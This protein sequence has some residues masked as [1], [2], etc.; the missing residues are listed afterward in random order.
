[1]TKE[2][3]IIPVDDDSDEEKYILYRPLIA[4]AFVG[5]R[6]MVDYVQERLA[7]A[8]TAGDKSD[9]ALFLHSIGFLV[10]DPP[11]PAEMGGEFS[12]ITAVLLLTNQCQLR[13]SY[14]YASAGERSAKTLSSELGMQAIDQV[15]QIAHENKAPK[16]DV[17][18]HGGGEPTLAWKT[19]QDCVAYTRQKSIPAKI[20]LTSNG[21]WS[22]AQRQWIIENIDGLSLSMDGSPATQDHHRPLASGKGSSELVMQTIATMDEQRYKYDIRMTA[23]APWDDLPKDVAFIC[24]HTGCQTIQVEPAFNIER[25]GH[26]DPNSREWEG[27]AQAYLEALDVANEAGRSFYYSGARLGLVTTTFCTAPYNALIV[28]P[29][30]V[31]MACYEVTDEDHPLYP[32]SQIGQYDQQQFA[33]DQQARQ[34]LHDMLAERRETC[35]DCYCYW[36]CAGGCYTRNFNPGPQGHLSRLNLCDLHQ[37]LLKELLLRE[38]AFGDGVWRGYPGLRKQIAY[39]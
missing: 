36:S 32:I 28:N 15:Y 18:F 35:K 19:I 8:P 39:V 9:I 7:G 5:N 10:E 33:V 11:T 17:S 4:R 38:I 31:M 1:M 20:S 14:C 23:T 27:F 25:G 16:F 37:T 24:Q 6:A 13:C 21:I 3:Y 30:G 2:L 22:P 34:H 26:L 12:P 29:D